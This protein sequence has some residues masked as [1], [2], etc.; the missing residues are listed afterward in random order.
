[1]T[2]L[3]LVFNHGHLFVKLEGNLWLYDT[4][5]PT[6]FGAAESLRF[7]GEQFELSSSY[8]GLTAAT[9]SQYVGVECSGLLGADVL[10]RFDH[11]LDT[12]G[13]NLTVST[14]ELSYD[15][16]SVRLDEFMGIPIVPARVGGSDY[17]MFFDT[18]AQISYFQDD[19]LT[20]FPSAGCV[21]DFYPGVGQFQTDT[22]EVPASLGGVAFVLRCG[23]LPGL[24]GAT[25]MIAGTQGIVRNQILNAR[26]SGFFPRR[27]LLCL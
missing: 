5:A 1:M 20:K 17:R 15:G 14:A 21:T 22:H 26:I 9:L 2:T 18:G 11:I 13:G 7:A 27:N 4:G 19:S 12:V 10:S 16:Q 25:L 3:P 6:S 8:F 23:S 24:L